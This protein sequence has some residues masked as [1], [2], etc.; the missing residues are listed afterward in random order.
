MSSYKTV[1][2][3]DPAYGNDGPMK[4][5]MQDWD[6]LYPIVNVK[7]SSNISFTGVVIFDSIQNTEYSING[8]FFKEK[9]YFEGDLLCLSSKQLFEWENHL[10]LQKLSG[11]ATG[12]L[13][14]DSIKYIPKGK[15]YKTYEL[16]H[17]HWE[18]EIEVLNTE[19]RLLA[20]LLVDNKES[21]DTTQARKETNFSRELLI[22]SLKASI[23]FTLRYRKSATVA[24]RNSG[25]QRQG[26]YQ[27][28]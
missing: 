4:G 12:F 27:G 17:P 20:Q 23:G 22:S 28:R 6:I 25:Y 18:G 8:M 13:L 3:H 11:S 1:S 24:S 16:L 14:V 10:Y 15:V 19:N 21:K 9:K 26:H 5:A 7:T 2:P